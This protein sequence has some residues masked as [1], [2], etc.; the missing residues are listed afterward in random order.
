MAVAD[1]DGDGSLD[2]VIANNGGPPSL[3][4]NRLGAGRH[5][6]RFRLEA[7]ESNPG[8][9]GARIVLWAAGHRQTRWVE[10]GS[11]YASQ[12]PYPVHFGL[13]DA[14][15]LEGL[16]IAWPSGRRERYSAGDLAALGGVDRQIVLVEGGGPAA[17]LSMN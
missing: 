2:L 15:T 13:G 6:V 10:A 17:E 14:R 1:L 9:V 5:W 3:Y 11:G 8:A 7:R 16:E 4:R 12:S